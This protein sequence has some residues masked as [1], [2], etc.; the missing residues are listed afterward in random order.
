MLANPV[1]R[2]YIDH[3]PHD[4]HIRCARLVLNRVQCAL[5]NEA[6]RF[7]RKVLRPALSVPKNKRAHPVHLH[8]M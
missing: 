8:R 6:L 7:V 1:H 5:L 3:I 2:K 4:I